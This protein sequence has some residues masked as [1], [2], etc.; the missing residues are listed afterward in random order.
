[1]VKVRVNK[2]LIENDGLFS[3]IIEYR[4]FTYYN[5]NRIVRLFEIE[6]LMDLLFWL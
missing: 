6:I 5:W 3:K 1:M 2:L 4:G